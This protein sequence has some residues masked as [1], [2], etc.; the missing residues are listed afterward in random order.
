MPGQRLL[1][2]AD[3]AGRARPAHRPDA[4]R[5]LHRGT[6]PI[7]GYQDARGDQCDNCG[8][9]LE[10]TDLLDPRS[11]IDGATP[12]FGETEH[13][14]LDLPALADALREYLEGREAT[15]TWRPNVINFSLNILDDIR[16][17]AMTRDI[18]W[19]IPLPGE[20]GAKYPTK[21]FYVWF[22]AVIGY[23]SASIEWARRSGDPERWR[24]WWNDEQ[25]RSYYFMGKDNITF[26]SQIWPAELLAYSGK[27]AKG[28]SPARTASSTSRPRS[29]RAS[30]S[31]WSPSSSPPAA[32]TSSACVTSCRPTDRTR[33]ATTSARP[34]RRTRTRT[35]P[36]PTSS[37]ATTPSSSPAG[38]PGQPHRSMVAKSFGEIPQPG[39]L[40]P[41]DDAVL[42]RV[43]GAFDE[44]G[45]LLSRNR[46]K[47]RSRRPCASWAT[48]TST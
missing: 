17:R 33:C 2:R 20:L 8:N 13:F 26:H 43:R 10:P 22:D 21:R 25:A 39:T 38:Q 12:Q 28:E 5:P 44:V 31:R 15:G 3:P 29:W 16:P 7:C 47:P 6:C 19:G 11:K 40:E 30:S 24:E 36:G 18:D 34:A 1:R 42:A 37:S 27:G 35:S 48:S 14:F 41:V 32:V 23:L 9:Q 45:D 46:Q 4:A